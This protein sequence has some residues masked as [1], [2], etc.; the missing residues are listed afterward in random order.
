MKRNNS[1]SL[2]SASIELSKIKVMLPVSFTGFTGYFIYNPHLTA[3]LFLVTA[4]VL[5]MAI[6]ASVLNQVQE[7]ET[8]A[9]MTRTCNRPLPSGRISVSA[10]LVYFAVALISGAALI[11]LSG[12][13]AAMIIGF[14]TLAWYNGVYTNLKRL[15]PFAV[16]PG[17]IT[18]ALP[19]LIGWVAAGGSPGDKTILLLQLLFF[20]GQIPHFW[21]LALKY[22]D[23]YNNAGFPVLESVMSFKRIKELIYVEVIISAAIAILLYFFGV[24]RNNFIFSILLTATIIVIWQFVSLTKGKERNNL[25]RYSLLLNTYFLLIMIL[26]ISDRI[27]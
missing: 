26:L 6:S 13:K 24:I 27:N 20:T 9:K 12:G 21:I 14:L 17:A 3:D 16:I 8:D 25:N 10:A 11:F 15:T 23:E 7:T 4:G 22:R 18:G 5:L 19:P 1:A 2:L